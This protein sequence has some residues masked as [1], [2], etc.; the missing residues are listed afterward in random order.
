VLSLA[1]QLLMI[2]A[3]TNA[4]QRPDIRVFWGVFVATMGVAVAA[5]FR[6]SG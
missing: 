5:A 1:A 4:T 6:W 3:A 2:A